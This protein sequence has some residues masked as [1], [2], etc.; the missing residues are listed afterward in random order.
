MSVVI[1][2]T[3][4]LRVKQ[5]CLTLY[6]VGSVITTD[7]LLFIYDLQITIDISIGVVHSSSPAGFSFVKYYNC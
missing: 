6:I 7:I 4:M 3:T 1:T 5:Y 2:F